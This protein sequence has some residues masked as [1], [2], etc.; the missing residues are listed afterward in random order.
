MCTFSISDHPFC[1]PSLT[2]T[3]P[4]PP[5]LFTWQSPPCVLSLGAIVQH[6]NTKDFQLVSGLHL[7]TLCSVR[8]HSHL[9]CCILGLSNPSN[10]NIITKKIL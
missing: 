1:C 8:K 7:L 6:N 4:P 5:A 10:V 9:S 3:P 2:Y